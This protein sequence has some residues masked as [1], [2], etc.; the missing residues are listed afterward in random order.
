METSCLWWI[1]L[2]FSW[3]AVF[4]FGKDGTSAQEWNS[5]LRQNRE[6]E[7]GGPDKE[8]CG[9]Q[10]RQDLI[11]IRYGGSSINQSNCKHTVF[12]MLLYKNVHIFSFL[13]IVSFP[14]YESSYSYSSFLL[15]CTVQCT[16]VSRQRLSA[17]CLFVDLM[18]A[19]ISCSKMSFFPQEGLHECPHQGGIRHQDGTV[20]CGTL[21]VSKDKDFLLNSSLYSWAEKH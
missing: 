11:M 1:V 6:D 10:N 7:E 16:V 8:A 9:R 15:P 13:V 4:H 18:P 3:V 5:K 20:E 21:W 14:R 12:S 2:C 17:L 19:N